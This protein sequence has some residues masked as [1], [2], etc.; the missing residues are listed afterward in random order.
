MEE[1]ARISGLVEPLERATREHALGQ[2]VG[3]G[4]ATIAPVDRA[5]L[6]VTGDVCDP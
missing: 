2:L 5:R 6:R 1:R 3:F 4:V